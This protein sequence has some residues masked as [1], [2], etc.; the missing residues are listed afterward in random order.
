MSKSMRAAL[1]VTLVATLFVVSGCSDGDPYPLVIDGQYVWTIGPFLCPVLVGILTEQ[2]TFFLQQLGRD[3]DWSFTDTNGNSVS[4]VGTYILDHLT[5]LMVILNGGRRIEA[6][7][8]MRSKFDGSARTL[9]GTV[10]I[11]FDSDGIC[12]GAFV[13]NWM[14]ETG[15][16]VVLPEKQLIVADSNGDIWELDPATGAE[17]FLCDTFQIEGLDPGQ[18]G[19]ISSMVF[20][21]RRNKIWMGQN[22]N[23]SRGIL[24]ELDETTGQATVAGGTDVFYPGLTQQLNTIRGVVNAGEG[25]GFIYDIDATTG[26]IDAGPD[27]T[28]V[29]DFRG[30]GVTSTDTGAFYLAADQTLYT[31]NSLNGEAQTVGPLTPV[32]FPVESPSSRF[33]INS[34]TMVGDI[35]YGLVRNGGESSGDTQFC[36]IDLDTGVMLYISTTSR[37]FDGLAC[38]PDGFIKKQ[39]LI[40]AGSS[41][42]IW[43]INQVTGDAEFCLDTFQV[44][45]GSSGNV[46]GV[47]SMIWNA[48]TQQVWMGTSTQGDFARMIFSLNPATG[49]ASVVADNNSTGV[50]GHSGMAQRP[51][52]DMAVFGTG[53]GEQSDFWGINNMTGVA[54]PIGDRAL[55][56]L[57]GGLG[58]T[59]VGNALCLA[60]R[61]E[62]Y[63]VNPATGAPTLTVDFDFSPFGQTQLD[64]PRINSMT[65]RADGTVYGILASGG[66]QDMGGLQT[67]LVVIDVATGLVTPVTGQPTT[68]DLDGLTFIPDDVIVNC[69]QPG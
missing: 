31:V 51:G 63:A 52:L 11:I 2:Q 43:K 47:S 66:R 36:R 57:G 15:I 7:V 13:G 68:V 61:D 46:G 62:L 45:G 54:S 65:T 58:L 41:G 25:F 17:T 32:G 14:I 21:T 48:K 37:I 38:I 42:D 64:N 59:F 26:D 18:V 22:S 39:E 4:F 30:L 56:G 29:D 19:R 60:A 53:G 40:A 10:D 8:D 16:P 6:E 24:W 55:S 67:Y 1:L 69:Q 9:D 23:D 28:G 20:N 5:G 49:A 33:R 34:M 12:A 35:A 3:V 44:E 27:V 50:V